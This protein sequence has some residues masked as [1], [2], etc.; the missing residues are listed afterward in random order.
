MNTYSIGKR[1]IVVFSFL[2]IIIAVSSFGTGCS[3]GGNPEL[4]KGFEGS[5][6]GE[7]K[8]SD[9]NSSVVNLALQQ[10]GTSTLIYKGLRGCTLT[11]EF[12]KNTGDNG[13]EYS[14]TNSSGGFCDNLLPGKLSL[15]KQGDKSLSCELTS[16][17]NKLSTPI[18]EKGTLRQSGK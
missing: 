1:T 18:S 15:R 9:G 5:W 4:D 17:N 12:L 6:T 2:A 3:A 11:V 10:T 14:I 8:A 13:R 7:V 16:L